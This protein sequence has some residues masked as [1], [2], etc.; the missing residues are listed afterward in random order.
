MIN[1]VGNHETIANEN[2]DLIFKST[3]DF[4][5]EDKYDDFLSNGCI[6]KCKIVFAWSAAKEYSLTG[7]EP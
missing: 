1:C 5:V 3:G 6:D 4:S 2:Y 7:K